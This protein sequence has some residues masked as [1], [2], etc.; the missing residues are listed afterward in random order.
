MIRYV[1]CALL[2][3]VFINIFMSFIFLFSTIEILKAKQ[4]QYDSLNRLNSISRVLQRRYKILPI[5]ESI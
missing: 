4:F 1:I 3:N 5:I 2:K